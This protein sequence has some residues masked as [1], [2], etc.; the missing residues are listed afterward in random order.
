[1]INVADRFAASQ[2]NRWM[3]PDA[4]RWVRSDAASFLAHGARVIDA[5]PALDRK[6]NPNQPRVPAGNPDGGQWA[7]G[8]GGIG[9]ELV[10]YRPDDRPVDL[11]EER[12]LG[13]HAVERHVG[14]SDVS[15]L[16]AVDGAVRY[17]RRNGDLTTGM[18]ESSF[19]SLEA[20]NKLVNSTISQNRGILERVI[21]GQ[22][23]RATLDAEFLSPTGREAYSRNEHSQTI[24]SDT[25]GVRVVVVPDRTVP[26][27]YRIDT[28]FPT[29]LNRKR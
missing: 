14:R 9:F 21:S 8:G 11:L 16:N 22:L 18:R 2:C 15:L 10:Q 26:K 3:Q 13:G 25:Y 28:A 24:M 20:A 4:A 23:S 1:M 6:Y 19:S 27:G 7:D 29:N 12:G 17:A 5:F